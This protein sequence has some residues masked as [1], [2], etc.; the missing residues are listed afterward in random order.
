MYLHNFYLEQLTNKSAVRSYPSSVKK[1]LPGNCFL[2]ARIHTAYRDPLEAFFSQDCNYFSE[3][4]YSADFFNYHVLLM[5]N[6]LL[7]HVLC[8]SQEAFVSYS[9]SNSA[10]KMSH[11]CVYSCNDVILNAY[12]IK[13]V[14]RLMHFLVTGRWTVFCV[15][16][17][18]A[19]IWALL[20][21]RA[22]KRA[23]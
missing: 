4:A 18:N 13:P 16:H 5:M 20:I 19:I 12:L 14:R 22:R 3:L 7:D 9:A 17:R 21:T 11:F 6:F 2:N 23:G 8:T 15:Q 1:E 10:P